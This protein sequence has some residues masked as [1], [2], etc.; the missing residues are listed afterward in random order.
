M[1]GY[2]TAFMFL[3]CLILTMNYLAGNNTD[4]A[5]KVAVYMVFFGAAFTFLANV[6]G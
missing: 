5:N 3:G 1:L 4:R 6:L 2:S